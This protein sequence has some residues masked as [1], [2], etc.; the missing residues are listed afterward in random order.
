MTTFK[1]TVKKENTDSSLVDG[2]YYNENTR[3]LA[4]D[5]Q[6]RVYVYSSVPKA[7][8]D[9]FVS[10]PSKGGYFR[11]FK[12]RFGPSEFLGDWEYIDFE[13]ESFKPAPSDGRFVTGGGT[14]PLPSTPTTSSTSGSTGVTL[15][16]PTT[17]T[18]NLR[19]HTVVF[20]AGG[21]EHEHNLNVASVDEAVNGLKVIADM[22]GVPMTV[23]RVVTHF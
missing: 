8:A 3:Q 4:V 22:L 14:E 6:D 23:K 7:V 12:S 11:G 1:Y 2:L 9:E 19:K 21:K 10:A 16:F 13:E 18:N 15:T 20:E 17:S 5:L